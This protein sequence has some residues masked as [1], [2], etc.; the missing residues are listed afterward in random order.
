MRILEVIR[1]LSDDFARQQ[2]FFEDECCATIRDMASALSSSI[3]FALDKFTVTESAKLP[4]GL[5]ISPNMDEEVKPYLA[6][7]VAWP[8]SLA[9]SIG[10]LDLQQR[11]WFRSELV[12]VGQAVGAGVL[13]CAHAYDWLDL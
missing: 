4:N 5:E 12:Y 11:N 2:Q 13:V 9:S 6:N 8:L 3:P 10:G 7:L 1:P